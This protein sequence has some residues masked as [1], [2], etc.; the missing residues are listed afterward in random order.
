[1]DVIEQSAGLLS[2]QSSKG[3]RGKRDMYRAYANISLSDSPSL[4]LR[5]FSQI[6]ADTIQQRTKFHLGRRDLY[7]LELSFCVM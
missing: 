1:M 2:S 4:V 5:S 3:T 6:K 7:L